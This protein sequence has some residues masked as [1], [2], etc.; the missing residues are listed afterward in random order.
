MTSAPPRDELARSDSLSD[1][2]VD[3]LADAEGVDPLELDPLYEAI[4]PDALDALFDPTDDD[5]RTGRVE[6]RTSGY[7]VEVT[8]T[9]RIHL[10]PVEA[11]EADS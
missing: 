6:F 1:A 7:R 8:S 5:R 11:L 3:A 9:G 4:D 2:V 10:T